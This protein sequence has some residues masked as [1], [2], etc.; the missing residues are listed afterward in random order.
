MKK[1]IFI[2]LITF[3]LLS[4]E[5]T[6]YRYKINGKVYISDSNWVYDGI[7]FTNTIGFDKDTI[8]YFNSDG[9]EVR[10]YPPYKIKDQYIYY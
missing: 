6:K 3:I 4:C 10:I 5:Q 9:S 7:W 8:Y 2:S 1:L